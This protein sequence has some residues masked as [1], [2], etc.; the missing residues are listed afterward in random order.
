MGHRWQ[1]AAFSGAGAGGQGRGR[2]K[3]GQ[4]VELNRTFRVAGEA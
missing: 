4:T 2:G 1:R 3:A